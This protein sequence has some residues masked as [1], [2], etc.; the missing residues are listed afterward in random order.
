MR[1]GVLARAKVEERVDVLEGVLM[2]Y[3]HQKSYSPQCS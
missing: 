3:R 1:V 2:H